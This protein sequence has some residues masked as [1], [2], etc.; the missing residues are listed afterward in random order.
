[1]DAHFNDWLII[2]QRCW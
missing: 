2:L 1:M